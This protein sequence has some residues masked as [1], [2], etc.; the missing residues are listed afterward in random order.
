[1]NDDDLGPGPNPVTETAMHLILIGMLALVAFAGLGLA[2]LTGL[3][4]P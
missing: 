3:V 4:T 1:M 2:Y